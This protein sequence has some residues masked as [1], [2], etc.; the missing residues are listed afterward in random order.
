MLRF[1]A[2]P[3]SFHRIG[4]SEPVL[5]FDL[6]PYEHRGMLR[7]GW[8]TREHDWQNSIHVGSAPPRPQGGVRW[9][10]CIHAVRESTCTRSSSSRVFGSPKAAAFSERR[11]G[12]VRP[13]PSY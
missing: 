8:L 12:S 6:E 11:N 13:L 5:K 7:R 1:V 10:F 3:R 2:A 4:A 9:R